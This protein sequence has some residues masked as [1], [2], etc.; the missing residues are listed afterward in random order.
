MHQKAF[1]SRVPPGP[2]GGAYSAPLEPLAGFRGVAPGK[3]RIWQGREGRI[4]G[5]DGGK[6][7]EEGEEEGEKFRPHSNFQKSAPIYTDS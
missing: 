7:K 4:K 3:G 6:G 2:A 1:G 5:E